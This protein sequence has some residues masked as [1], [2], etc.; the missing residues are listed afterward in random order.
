MG[1]GGRIY[2][3]K[4]KSRFF[5]LFIPYI[6]WNF[7]VIIRE[8]FSQIF[9]SDLMAGNKKLYDDYSLYDY[10][11][12]LFAT[13]HMPPD[14]PLWFIRDLMILVVISPIIYYAIKYF[15]RYFIILL[16]IIWLTPSLCNFSPIDFRGILFFSL[17]AWISIKKIDFLQTLISK[18]N[19]F[20]ALYIVLILLWMISDNN[21]LRQI[22]IFSGITVAFAYVAKGIEIG[23]LHI[24]KFLTSATFYI[25][26]FHGYYILLVNK[27]V[28]RHLPVQNDFTL[29]ATYLLSAVFIVSI[30]LLFYYLLRKYFP[31]FTAIICGSR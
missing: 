12:A 28:G 1:G 20:L 2:L 10:F 19:I 11:D 21:I 6:F 7:V 22:S 14:Y 15:H 30:G 25:Y 23:K 29:I 13:S 4:L 26:A 16:T 27:H 3:K 5:S 9:F 31:K 17:G 24:N 8:L 18:R